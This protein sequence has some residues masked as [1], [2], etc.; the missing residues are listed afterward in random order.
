MGVREARQLEGVVSW[1]GRPG[2]QPLD[3]PKTDFAV[4]DSCANTLCSTLCS[5]RLI[6]LRLHA[7]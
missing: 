6:N 4:P 2:H 7:G 3:P 1:S 5:C